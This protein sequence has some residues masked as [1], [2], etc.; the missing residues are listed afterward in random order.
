M[1]PTVLDCQKCTRPKQWNRANFLLQTA[2]ICIFWIMAVNDASLA[3]Q[4]PHNQQSSNVQFR[5]LLQVP[6]PPVPS[7]R[8]KLKSQTAVPPPP[9]ISK[10]P[11]GVTVASRGKS[12]F[13]SVKTPTDDIKQL[14]SG[15]IQQQV[16]AKV[17]KAPVKSVSPPPTV[18][19][20]NAQ[21]QIRQVS[22]SASLGQPKIQAAPLPPPFGTTVTQEFTAPSASSA[23]TF[24][25][26]LINS[27]SQQAPLPPLPGTPTPTFNQPINSQTPT[28]SFIPNTPAPT[29]QLLNPQAITHSSVPSTSATQTSNQ[30]LNCQVVSSPAVSGN[31]APTFNQLLNCQATTQSA[32]PN[33]PASTFNQLLNC[34]VATSPSGTST[35]TSNQYLN[36]Q[37]VSSLPVTQTVPPPQTQA[38]TTPTVPT[39]PSLTPPSATPPSL[40]PPSATPNTPQPVDRSRPLLRS[41]A[42]QEPS[43]QVQG[44]YITQGDDSAAR[45]RLSAVYPVTPQLLVGATLDLVTGENLLVDSGGDGLNINEL[46]LA[47]SVGGAPNLRFV[48]GQIDLTSYFDRNSF[49]KDGASQF[50]NPIFQTNPALSATGIASRTGLLV[51]WSVTDNIEAKAA[52]FSSSNKISDFA[53]DG[54]AGEVAIR[55]G[56]AI[57]RG[58]YASDRDAGIRDTFPESFGLARNTQ[59]TIFGPQKDDREEAYGLNAEVFVPELK[60]GLFG[61]YG[62]YENRDLGKGADT[63][64]F[65]LSFLDLFT[66]DDR[67]GLAYGRA[68]SNDSL[69]RGDNPDVLELFYD[70]EFLPNL[71]FGFTVQGRDGF[72]ETVLGVRVRTEFDVTPRG[73]RSQ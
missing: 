9:G 59:G 19:A 40:T 5:E 17:P 60:L 3:Q 45:G 57:I 26:V 49:A 47:T 63:Y 50:F 34:Q 42:L 43:L 41:T 62:R 53:L 16:P 10:Q 51:N 6:K 29:N 39:P 20:Q 38:Q 66:P 68:L 56:N 46:F 35:P 24:N 64:S 21:E 67:L 4:N 54:F 48:L 11:T 71:R 7:K 70:F 55:Y 15:F 23:P 27:Q 14:E 37:V 18:T 30:L 65:G 44:V 1:R 25:Q 33:T 2:S 32:V 69:R 52:V 61:R 8:Q 73:R 28:Q 22:G 36:C 12:S 72:E 31:A 58:T 13:E